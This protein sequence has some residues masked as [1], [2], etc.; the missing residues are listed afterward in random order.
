MAAFVSRRN[1][2]LFAILNDAN[3]IEAA[4]RVDFAGLRLLQPR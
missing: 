4:N 1:G 2:R 3:V